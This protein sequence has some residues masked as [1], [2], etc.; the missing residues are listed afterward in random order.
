MR[1]AYFTSDF[2][3]FQTPGDGKSNPPLFSESWLA[4]LCIEKCITEDPMAFLTHLEKWSQEFAPNIFDTTSRLVI[5]FGKSYDRPS[6]GWNSDN[7]QALP[8]PTTLLRIAFDTV[9]ELSLPFFQVLLGCMVARHKETANGLQDLEALVLDVTKTAVSDRSSIWPKLFIG[10]NSDIGRQV[11]CCQLH[12]PYALNL[13]FCV[14]PD[15]VVLRGHHP[16]KYELREEH[17][18]YTRTRLCGTIARRRGSRR[19]HFKGCQG[20]LRAYSA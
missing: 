9:D 16:G 19:Q 12:H 6:A 5:L 11:S 2:A 18:R 13:H 20:Q 15:S 17:V 4:Q 3:A 1:L 10:Q 7:T 8:A 14:L